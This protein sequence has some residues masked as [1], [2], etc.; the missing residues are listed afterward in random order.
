MLLPWTESVK[1]R[2]L[3]STKAQEILQRLSINITIGEKLTI[4]DKSNVTIE[5]TAE[6]V[7]P[8]SLS[9]SK[10]GVKLNSLQTNLLHLRN[11]AREDTGRYTCTAE[12]FLGFVS[13][14]TLLSV[15]GRYMFWR[16]VENFVLEQWEFFSLQSQKMVVGLF[17]LR[18]VST[19]ISER[20]VWKAVL[21]FPSCFFF[22]LSF[23]KKHGATS[24]SKTEQNVPQKG[25]ILC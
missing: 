13:Q 11:I 17:W 15:R 5:C 20:L 1:P 4:L 2:I 14:S 6:G 10:D 16:H 18:Q 12:N 21:V 25:C 7:P 19:P 9:W 23:N 3:F 8:P 24:L 22:L